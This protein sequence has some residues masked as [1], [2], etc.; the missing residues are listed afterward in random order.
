[1]CGFFARFLN[2][3]QKYES[4]KSFSDVTKSD[5]NNNTYFSPNPIEDDLTTQLAS[6]NTKWSIDRVLQDQMLSDNE[7]YQALLVLKQQFEHKNNLKGFQD[8]QTFNARFIKNPTQIIENNSDRFIQILH[9]GDSHW[10]TV[11][12]INTRSNRQVNIYDSLYKEHTYESNQMLINFFKRVYESKMCEDNESIILVDEIKV[13]S[14]SIQPVQIQSNATLCGVYAIA[15]AYDLCN[16]C[17][18]SKQYY[19]E[20][21]LRK[22][23]FKCLRAKRFDEFPKI[24]SNCGEIQKSHLVKTDYS[25]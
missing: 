2:Y 19:N 22:H 5:S 21:K 9:D 11:T 1:M 25:I 14:C 20:Q 10:I 15:F 4:N 8:P 24:T 7:I 18:P 12:N 3:F 16:D 23:L 13:I 17:D 6:P